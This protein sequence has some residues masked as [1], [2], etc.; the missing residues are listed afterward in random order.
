[1]DCGPSFESHFSHPTNSHTAQNSLA[2]GNSQNTN[3]P[4]KNCSV[5]REERALLVIF[6]PPFSISHRYSPH[7]FSNGTA[8]LVVL[9]L[10]LYD[11][12]G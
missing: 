9:R 5:S 6:K 3:K 12:R 7:Q 1:M 2:T 8:R 10:E 11:S 4:F